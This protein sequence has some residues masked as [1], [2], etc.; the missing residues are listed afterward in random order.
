MANGDNPELNKS[1]PLE[2]AGHTQYQMLIGMLNWIVTIGR[3]DVAFATAITTTQLYRR[4]LLHYATCGSTI[5]GSLA[6]PAQILGQV[7][8]VMWSIPNHSG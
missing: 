5:Y 4:L 1:V 3:L 8:S 7:Q 6:K 2:G